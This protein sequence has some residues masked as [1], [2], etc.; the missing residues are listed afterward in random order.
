MDPRNAERLQHL[1]ETRHS[2]RVPFD[3]AWPVGDDELSRI[4][5]AARWAPT[6]HNMQNFRLIAVDDPETL[7]ALGRI[8]ASV[9]P[10]FIAEN[11]RQ[12]SWSVDE[13]ERRGVGLLASAFPPSWWTADPARAPTGV[14]RLLSEMIAGAPMVLVVAFDAS[15]R[16]PASEGDRLGMISLGCVL[17]NMWLT[18]QALR[19]DLQ[20]VSALA[21]PGAEPEIRQ[22]LQIPPPWQIAFALRLGHATVRP[23]TP[24]V[25]RSAKICVDR[26]RFR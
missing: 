4:V 22:L 21:E 1:I 15:Q 11:Y 16:A 8:R 13:L 14:S 12:L 9:S 20:V 2:S 10:V 24:R 18:A 17:E 6:A 5:E 7:A 23:T 25:R 19:L 26:N 3:P